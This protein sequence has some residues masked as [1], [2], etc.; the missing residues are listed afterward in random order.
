MLLGVIIG[1]I[2][3]GLLS[4]IGVGTS[5]LQWAAFLVVAGIGIGTGRQQ[6]YIAVQLVLKYVRQ[7]REILPL[8]DRW[9]RGDDIPIGNGACL[10]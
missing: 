10:P 8:T 2:G 3:A 1:S 4:R 9:S 5:T 7:A 6:P